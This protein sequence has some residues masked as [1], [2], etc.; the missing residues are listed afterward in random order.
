MQFSRRGN[1][2]RT[3]GRRQRNKTLLREPLTH[4]SHR[5]M[6]LHL[7]LVT[8]CPGLK[9]WRSLVRSVSPQSPETCLVTRWRRVT[10]G[11]PVTTP[12]C[13]T[14]HN[15]A[16]L[17]A[18]PRDLGGHTSSLTSRPPAQRSR[19]DLRGRA[20]C[21]DGSLSARTICSLPS[22]EKRPRARPGL[23]PSDCPASV[24]RAGGASP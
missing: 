4:Y 17:S 15:A 10:R 5:Q 7:Q 14:T 6:T 23:T 12:T 3:D 8:Q 1:I 19:Q 9:S 11:S 20:D 21:H 18:D 22:E 13:F 24:Y 16:A 2:Q